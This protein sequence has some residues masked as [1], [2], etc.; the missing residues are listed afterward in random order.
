MCPPELSVLSTGLSRAAPS[1]GAVGAL[2]KHP[3][4]YHR[5]PSGKSHALTKLGKEALPV[6][7]ELS[8]VPE[9]SGGSEWDPQFLPSGVLR[10]D[11]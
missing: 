7:G 6:Q 8:N 10:W 4:L 2:Q 3:Q 9:G 5:I 11:T 1:L